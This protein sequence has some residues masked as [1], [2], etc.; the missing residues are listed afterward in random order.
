MCH[1]SERKATSFLGGAPQDAPATHDNVTA[2]E[3]CHASGIQGMFRGV[4]ALVQR[5]RR[6]VIQHGHRLLADN[7]AGIHARINKVHGAAGDSDTM[8]QRLLPGRQPG[9]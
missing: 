1:N 7:R 6:V 4:N 3:R 8:S 9:K 5:F 2:G